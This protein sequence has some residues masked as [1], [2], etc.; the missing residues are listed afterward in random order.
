M[1]SR[2]KYGQRARGQAVAALLPDGRV[3]VAGGD[4]STGITAEIYDPVA[5]AWTPAASMGRNH[6]P[7]R[8]TVLQSGK[9][10]V[11]GGGGLFNAGSQPELYDANANAWSAAG[12]MASSL[13][14]YH[15]ATLL[16][17]GK[18]LVVGGD[19]GQ[20][21]AELYDPATNSWSPAASMAI[22]RYAHTATLLRS[23]KVLVTGGYTVTSSYDSATAT[24]RDVR[25]NHRFLDDCRPYE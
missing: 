4:N 24:V 15:T 1:G 22:P 16:P 8:A 11:S 6:I 13:R 10:L 21:T 17:S 20:A 25:P 3:L 19:P 14:L 18:V 2:G 7:A 9:V 5:N 12:V 23:G